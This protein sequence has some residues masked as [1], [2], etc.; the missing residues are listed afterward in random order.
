MTIEITALE[1]QTIIGILDFER[2]TPQRVRIDCRI[3][4]DYD[5][6]FINYA[7]VASHIQELMQKEQFEL[8]ETALLRL[9]VTLK[10]TFPLIKVLFLKISKPDILDNCEVSLSE[11]TK[12]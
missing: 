4:Y 11:T 12:Y 7:L 5:T 9:K 1:F 6:A 2:K 10:E 3:D 8:I